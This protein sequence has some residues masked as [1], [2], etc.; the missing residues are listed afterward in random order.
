M[1]ISCINKL[2]MNW[3]QDYKRMTQTENKD[4]TDQTIH[5]IRECLSK[6]VLRSDLKNYISLLILALNTPIF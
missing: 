1:Y 4:K 5:I 3:N 6:C 2:D